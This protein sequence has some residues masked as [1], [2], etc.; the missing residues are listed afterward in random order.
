MFSALTQ[1]C[2]VVHEH[3]LPFLS[4]LWISVHLMDD[5]NSH[6][7][8]CS[9]HSM[10][11]EEAV[12]ELRAP[13]EIRLGLQLGAAEEQQNEGRNT[14]RNDQASPPASMWCTVM[15][16][17]L[18]TCST[19]S[20]QEHAGVSSSLLLSTPFCPHTQILISI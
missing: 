18:P 12:T 17:P 13:G 8:S 15:Q 9:A 10:K 6:V 1:S 19:T 3:I 5:A 2:S 20:R 14:S 11:Q 16:T 7:S 4:P